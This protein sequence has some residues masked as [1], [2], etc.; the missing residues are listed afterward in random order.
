MLALSHKKVVGN[1]NIFMSEGEGGEEEGGKVVKQ[2]KL[3]SKK[4]PQASPTSP[5]TFN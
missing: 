2:L 1:K 5:G 4:T 3:H